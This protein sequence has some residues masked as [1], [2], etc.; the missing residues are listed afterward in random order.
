VSA[1]QDRLLY[2]VPEAAALLAVSPSFVWG[3]LQRGEL[4]GVKV[5]RSRKVT[6]AELERYVAS[7]SEATG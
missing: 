7:L 2:T 6:A 3:L 5:G 1:I 4:T